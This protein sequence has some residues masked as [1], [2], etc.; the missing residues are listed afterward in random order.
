MLFEL[1]PQQNF[2]IGQPADFDKTAQHS[3][4]WPN[5]VVYR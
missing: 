4:K 5:S 1:T 2:L 3:S